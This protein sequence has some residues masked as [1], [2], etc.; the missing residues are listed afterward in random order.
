MQCTSP[1]DTVLPNSVFQF[2]IK[3]RDWFFLNNLRV[4]LYR[5]T[6]Q[7]P[8]LGNTTRKKPTTFNRKAVPATEIDFI[9][10]L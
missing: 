5:F 6:D 3:L 8:G 7:L 10:L 9:D 4:Y 1:R 2:S